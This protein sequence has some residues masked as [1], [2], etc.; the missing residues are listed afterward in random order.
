MDDCG[1]PDAHR[2]L[3]SSVSES[4]QQLINRLL[5]IYGLNAQD[6]ESN[7]YC[8]KQINI[9]AKHERLPLDVP[10]QVYLHPDDRPLQIMRRSMALYPN[11]RTELRLI[12]AQDAG[13]MGDDASSQQYVNIPQ[14]RKTSDSGDDDEVLEEETEI[15]R[16]SGRTTPGDRSA[17]LISPALDISSRPPGLAPVFLNG[18][19]VTGPTPISEGTVIRLGRHLNLRYIEQP[20][21][22]SVAGINKQRSAM[23]GSTPALVSRTPGDVHQRSA[24]LE[25]RPNSDTV[26]RSAKA[27]VKE[28]KQRAAT[29]GTL[30]DDP[31]VEL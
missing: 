23:S 5:T 13:A 1:L 24:T 22:T 4:A 20:A 11:I 7:Q 17:V 28:Y 9:P 19:K 10:A 6:F 18:R 3:K 21:G 14:Q 16:D 27:S 30:P 15:S 31:E 8:L 29:L 12:N 2:Q 25:P 26:A